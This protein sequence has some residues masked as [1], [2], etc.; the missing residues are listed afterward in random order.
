M[1]GKGVSHE[2]HKDSRK[3]FRGNRIGCQHIDASIGP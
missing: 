3:F 1:S 2:W